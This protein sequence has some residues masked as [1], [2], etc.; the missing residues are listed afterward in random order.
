M[1]Y[2]SKDDERK[3]LAK[4]RKIIDTLGADSYVAAAFDGCFEVAEQNID[5]D[6][7]CSLK[8]QIESRNKEIF[9][10]Q[11][12]NS[13]LRLDLKAE[14]E[15]HELAIKNLQTASSNCADFKDTIQDLKTEINRL[16]A[17]LSN[18]SLIEETNRAYYKDLLNTKDDE[19]IRLKAKLYDLTT[20]E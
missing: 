15:Y 16:N 4:I 6:W 7:A 3:A 12:E 20:G 9:K 11:L 17:E 2:I 14:K 18:V 13:N 19:I 10:L 5:N 8:E 1:E